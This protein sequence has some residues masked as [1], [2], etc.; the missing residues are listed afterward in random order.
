MYRKHPAYSDDYIN[1]RLA[2]LARSPLHSFGLLPGAF[3]HAL[4][5]IFRLISLSIFLYR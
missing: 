4:H 3:V 2:P 5:V 1:G